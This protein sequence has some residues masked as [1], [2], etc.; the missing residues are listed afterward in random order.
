M[1]GSTIKLLKTDINLLLLLLLTAEMM[2]TMV[3]SNAMAKDRKAS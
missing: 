3:F 2:F 1:S